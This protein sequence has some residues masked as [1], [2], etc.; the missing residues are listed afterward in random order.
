MKK[1]TIILIVSMITS[2]MV[3]ADGSSFPLGNPNSNSGGNN[4]ANNANI[5]IVPQPVVIQPNF[6]PQIGNNN[7]SS[8]QDPINSG[9]IVVN[10]GNN[11]QSG[12]KMLSSNDNAAV[13]LNTFK[14][15]EELRKQLSKNSGNMQQAPLSQATAAIIPEKPISASMIGYLILSG[16]Q[17]IATIQYGD[18]STLEVQLGSLV[19]GYKVVKITTDAITLT[20]YDKTVSGKSTIIVRKSN[21]VTTQSGVS[22]S[23]SQQFDMDKT[24][25]IGF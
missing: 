18:N 16:G 21:P 6:V 20:K 14:K 9:N 17:K 15:Q 8:Q 13:D 23:T 3:F 12:S 7:S 4:I 11:T 24:S 22:Y 5:P 19:A 10:N 1:K 2:T 25:K